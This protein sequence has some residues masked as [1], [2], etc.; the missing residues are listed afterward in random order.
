MVAAA[1]MPVRD[2]SAD[3]ATPLY[4]VALNTPSF[5]HEQCVTCPLPFCPAACVSS[6][7]RPIDRTMADSGRIE[8]PLPNRRVSANPTLWE[9]ATVARDTRVLASTLKGRTD[10][11]WF[12]RWR[13]LEPSA[14][15]NDGLL[16]VLMH[17]CR[18]RQ[19]VRALASLMPT[20]TPNTLSSTW[21]PCCWNSPPLGQT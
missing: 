11:V 4:H 21:A 10:V 14:R 16:A 9:E 3:A 18:A 12:C 2:P 6:V 5:S 17:L 13:L 7:R 1:R 8:S 15:V 19:V 20:R